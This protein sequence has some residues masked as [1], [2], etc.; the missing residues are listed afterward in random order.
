MISRF[1]LTGGRKLSFQTFPGIT[2][3]FIFSSTGEF[4]FVALAIR[5]L[6]GF[7]YQGWN[8][9]SNHFPSARYHSEHYALLGH[10][11]SNA[12]TY[13]ILGE[14]IYNLCPCIHSINVY[15]LLWG[16]HFDVGDILIGDTGKILTFMGQKVSATFHTPTYLESAVCSHLS[17]LGAVFIPGPTYFPTTCSLRSQNFMDI[18]FFFLLDFGEKQL[19]WLTDHH[20]GLLVN[21]LMVSHL[22]VVLTSQRGGRLSQPSQSRLLVPHIRK[23]SMNCAILNADGIFEGVERN[24]PI[25]FIYFS[26]VL[27][28]ISHSPW[29]RYSREGT[30]GAGPEVT[31]LS[32]MQKESAATTKCSDAFISTL[33]NPGCLGTFCKT[34]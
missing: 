18:S 22:R 23:C 13:S 24:L 15:P 11:E 19:L 5:F 28:L 17:I 34:G 1:L 7:C 32:Q 26:P 33:N 30:Y 2:S 10:R 25:Y 21:N 9:E 8:H 12:N 20:N 16:T 31:T 29:L 3:S 6:L 4:Y 14:E 27:I